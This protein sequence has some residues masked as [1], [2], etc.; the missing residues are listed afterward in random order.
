MSPRAPKPTRTYRSHRRAR[1]LALWFLRAMTL[2]VAFGI[3]LAFTAATARAGSDSPTP[4]VVDT[5][6]VTLPAGETFHAHGHV[7]VRTADGRTFGVHLDPNNGHPGATWIGAT[8]IPWTALGIPTTACVT[9]VQ[10]STHDEHYGEGGQPP[11]CLTRP[12]QEPTWTPTPDPTPTTSPTA[13]PS[14]SS[15]S[16]PTP[17]TA[18]PTPEPSGEPTSTPTPAAPPAPERPSTPPTAPSSSPSTGSAPPPTSERAEV[19]AAGL[20]DDGH[21]LYELDSRDALAATG[22]DPFWTVIAAAAS[23]GVGWQ[24]RRLVRDN[25]GGQR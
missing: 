10:I 16:T 17:A 18:T 12:T 13:S 22:I 5:S 4:Y 8:S 1:G 9:W 24:I 3:G 6:G 11:V 21:P 23:I 7:N 15:S 2:L 14:P 20:D 25:R 19:S